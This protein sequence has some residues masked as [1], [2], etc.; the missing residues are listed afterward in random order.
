MTPTPS[1]IR[2][3]CI[4]DLPDITAVMK[5]MIDAETDMKCVGCSHSANGLVEDVGRLNPPADASE[6]PLIVVLDAS[7]PG[8]DSFEALRELATAFP[9]VRTIIYSGYEGREFADRAIDAGAWGCVA[10]GDDPSA[11]VAAVR[12]VA[13]GNTC[14]PE[15]ALGAMA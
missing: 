11:I 3:L 6:S 15:A 8:K 2:V 4:D 5:L 14:F 12:E 13:A 10:K 1:P 9:V 7:M